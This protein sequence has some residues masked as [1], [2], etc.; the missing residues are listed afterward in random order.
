MSIPLINMGSIV[1][2]QNLV[3]L[4]R[5]NFQSGLQTLYRSIYK[6]YK[7]RPKL[8]GIEKDKH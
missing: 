7:K 1:E 5:T 6:R 4:G 2:K 8:S 3:S